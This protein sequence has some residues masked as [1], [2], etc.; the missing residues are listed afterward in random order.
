MPPI[1]VSSH[2]RYTNVAIILHWMIAAL[3]IG[4]VAGGFLMVNLG[5]T[6]S[7]LKFELFQWHKSFG[8]MIL[9][10][11][12]IRIVW[13]LTHRPPA[14]PDSLKSYERALARLTHVGFYVLLVAAPLAGWALVSASPFASSVQTYLFGVIHLPHLPFFEDVENRRE[15]AGQIAEAHELLAFGIITL[16]L[17]HVGAALKHHFVDRDGVLQRMA[18]FLAHRKSIQS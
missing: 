17:L 11:T 2:S 3:I 9:V 7:A 15:V 16:F 14:L 5:E 1:F 13:R 8:I 18:P 6:Q 4:Q 10:L 12:L